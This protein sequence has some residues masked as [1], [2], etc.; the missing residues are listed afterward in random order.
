M[1]F[2]GKYAVCAGKSF[3]NADVWLQTKKLDM[4]FVNLANKKARRSR[5]VKGTRLTGNPISFCRPFC[6]YFYRRMA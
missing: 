3:L 6:L 5:K 4:A 2:S 1:D